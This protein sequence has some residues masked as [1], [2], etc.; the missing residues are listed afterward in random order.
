MRSSVTLPQV[1]ETFGTWAVKGGGVKKT[2]TMVTDY[3]P[4]H[5]FEAGFVRAFKEAAAR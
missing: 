4:G 2:Y 1:A 5:D 3:G